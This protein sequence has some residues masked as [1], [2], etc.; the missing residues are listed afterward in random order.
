MLETTKEYIFC[1]TESKDHRVYIVV[2]WYVRE[3]KKVLNKPIISR[4][5]EYL[6]ALECTLPFSQSRN[7]V[8]IA[9]DNIHRHILFFEHSTDNFTAIITLDIDTRT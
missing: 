3:G 5:K 2:V 6:P 7:F 4:A 9:L 1:V 8:P